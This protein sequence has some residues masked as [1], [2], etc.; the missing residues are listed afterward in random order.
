MG[1]YFKIFLLF[2]CSVFFITGCNK[3]DE[4]MIKFGLKNSD[5]EI[6]KEGNIKKII[7][8]NT[9][10]KSFTFIVQD[11]STILDFYDIFS[12]AKEVEYKITLQPDYTITLEGKDSDSYKYYYISGLDK[13]ELGNLYNDDN[14]YI[15]SKKLDND[16]I[17]YFWNIRKPINFNLVYY[18]TMI[19]ALKSYR[20]ET[21]Y[22][23][24]IGVD[25]YDDIETTKFLLSLDIEEFKNNLEDNNKIMEKNSD[26]NTNT[27][28][29]KII[30][31]GYKTDIYKC[32][33]E[34]YNKDENK[35]TTYY[36]VNNYLENSWKFNLYY[37]EP[38]GY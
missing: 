24:T 28:T 26:S 11:K 18:E 19:M 25:F 38:E 10:D 14:N 37:S 1:K 9:R 12:K 36:Y 15:V 2:I 20:E 32:R 22:E 27:I 5:F 21:N 3:I 6:I 30:T 35:T 29:M 4:T 31:D 16:I 17:N 33:I 8:E 23:G 7:I 34:F 13:T